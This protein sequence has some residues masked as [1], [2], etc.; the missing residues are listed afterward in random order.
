MQKGQKVSHVV[1]DVE[2]KRH[3]AFNL[4]V[5]PI[6]VV[7]SLITIL[8]EPAVKPVLFYTF[9]SYVIVDTLW[10]AIKPS[11]VAS[12]LFIIGHHFVTAAA[13]IFAYLDG[14]ELWKWGLIGPLVE[15]NTWFLL[16]RRTW[17]R[18][19]VVEALFYSSWVGLRLI[20]Y[21]VALYQYV[22]AW[23]V[24]VNQRS[25]VDSIGWHIMLLS[26]TALNYLNMKWSYDLFLK[27][28]TGKKGL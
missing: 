21:P 18:P 2:L 23:F 14:D 8:R 10:L 5:L 4:C 27:S 1:D 9:L 12:P 13:W 3:D 11:S 24:I 22:Q 7:C 15:I 20:L 16:A 26:A 28:Q 17:N 19:L 6:V 25:F